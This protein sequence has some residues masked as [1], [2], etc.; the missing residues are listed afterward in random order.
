MVVFWYRLKI[1]SH[2][3]V[4][5]II[6]LGCFKENERLK[7]ESDEARATVDCQTEKIASLLAQNQKYLEQSN[8][9]LEQRNESFQVHVLIDELEF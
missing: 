7:K 4:L 9:M 3:S 8:I 6:F 1:K 5:S 2:L